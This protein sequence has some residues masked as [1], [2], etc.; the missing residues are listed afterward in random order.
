MW[1]PISRADQS[2]QT[3]GE[4]QFPRRPRL[5]LLQRPR[6]SRWAPPR[7][8][9]CRRQCLKMGPRWVPWWQQR[10]RR[11]RPRRPLMKALEVQIKEALRPL[12]V[13][14]TS[15][16]SSPPS[17]TSRR[18]S[19]TAMETRLAELRSRF[20]HDPLFRGSSANAIHSF[21][22]SASR[23]S[24]CLMGSLTWLKISK[25]SIGPKMW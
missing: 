19:L 22:T 13:R 12:A 24:P 11:S 15:P 8:Q 5:R 14:F 2:D 4:G 23:R 6:P 20:R 18:H 3:P 17:P 1:S 7:R 10:Q 21:V 25:L 16:P 9:R